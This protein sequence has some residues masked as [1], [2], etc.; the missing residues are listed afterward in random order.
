MPAAAAAAGSPSSAP[1]SS[2]SSPDLHKNEASGRRALALKHSLI[3]CLVTMTPPL[4]AQTRE[5]GTQARGT[6]TPRRRGCTH[7]WLAGTWVC[8]RTRI[9]SEWHACSCA[10]VRQ[11]VRGGSRASACSR[12]WLAPVGQVAGAHGRRLVTHLASLRMLDARDDDRDSTLLN[13]NSNGINNQATRGRER[14]RARYQDLSERHDVN[15]GDIRSVRLTA[16]G[17]GSFR[18]QRSGAATTGGGASSGGAGSREHRGSLGQHR[19]RE[20]RRRS[21]SGSG[22]GSSL[23]R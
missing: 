10:S 22:S 13:S 20:P 6:T 14:A 17:L 4:S 19:G 16:F 21:G 23:G 8:W 2:S 1:S 12:G 9:S 11:R 7:L 5:S 3:H 15:V 18:A